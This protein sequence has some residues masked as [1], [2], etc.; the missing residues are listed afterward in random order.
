MEGPFPDLCSQ[1]RAE[2]GKMAVR[3]SQQRGLSWIDLNS[4]L[5][6]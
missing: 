2:A 1:A 5:T 4:Q 6:S 3:Y